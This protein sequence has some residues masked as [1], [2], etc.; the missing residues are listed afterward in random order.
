MTLDIKQATAHD[1]HEVSTWVTGDGAPT[2]MGGAYSPLSGL[3]DLSNPNNGWCAF[4]DDELVAYASLMVNSNNDAML[5]FIVK[6]SRR[7]EGIAK[8]FIPMLLEQ[9]NLGSFSRIIGTPQLED[10]ASQ[11]VLTHAGFHKTGFNPDGLP[12][13]ERR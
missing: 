6:P 4:T 9:E 2:G 10:I 5:G 11:K 8:T 7:R 12:I 1:L 3:V 13:Y